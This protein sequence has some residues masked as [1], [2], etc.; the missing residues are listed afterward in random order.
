MNLE[1]PVEEETKESP[2]FASIVARSTSG[3]SAPAAGRGKRTT[4]TSVDFHDLV[5]MLSSASD[6]SAMSA[7]FDPHGSNGSSDALPLP[8][9]SSSPATSQSSNLPNARRR[10]SISR[11]RSNSLKLKNSLL[12]M[13]GQMTGSHDRTSDGTNAPHETSPGATPGPMTAPPTVA[14]RSH[15]ASPSKQSSQQQNGTARQ[16]SHDNLR[17]EVHRLEEQL[18]KMNHQVALK[19]DGAKLLLRHFRH[20]NYNLPE[21]V[22]GFEYDSPSPTNNGKKAHH[23]RSNNRLRNSGGSKSER[24]HSSS[25]VSP[26][27]SS[28]QESSSS[29][30]SN[31]FNNNSSSSDQPSSAMSFTPGSSPLLT[32]TKV[33]SSAGSFRNSQP[34][35]ER[36]GDAPCCKR[37]KK[38]FKTF[39]RNRHHC[40]CCG[41]VF[42]G[43]CTSN[44]MNLPEFGYYDVV[45]VCNICYNSG[46]DG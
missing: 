13:M 42:C 4:A 36:D 22:T 5:S 21:T 24:F 17:R 8:E 35:W 23:H 19:E 45:R 18:A 46:E 38:K 33:I 2:S 16:R 30:T 44:R 40:R 6:Q 43:R 10:K 27:S 15:F 20:Y 31:K 37:C 12:S 39:Y 3:P 7:T 1:Y 25:I 26:S 34:V 28:S 29:N 14:V 41:Y 9:L 32:T 11:S